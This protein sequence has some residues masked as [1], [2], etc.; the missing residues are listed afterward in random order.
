M[1]LL[2]TVLSGS[3]CP[4]LLHSNAPDNMDSIHSI[5]SSKIANIHA[6]FFPKHQTYSNPTSYVIIK[7]LQVVK[8]C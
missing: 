8:N 5:V 3:D 6:I 2:G 4:I 7:T 1:S